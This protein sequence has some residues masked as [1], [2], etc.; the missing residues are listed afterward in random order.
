[1][2]MYSLDACEQLIDRYANKYGGEVL[3][4]REGVLG[5]GTVLLTA[6]GKKTV[7]IQERYLNAWSSG[8]TIRRY[9]KIPKKYENQREV[10]V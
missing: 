6:E 10:L 7:I 2:T 1:M 4:L 9:N 5:L 3:T 8:H